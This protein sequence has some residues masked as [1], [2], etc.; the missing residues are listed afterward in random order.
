[1]ESAIRQY[2]LHRHRGD[3]GDLVSGMAVTM[4]L[5]VAHGHPKAA[6][7]VGFLNGGIA[8]GAALHNIRVA[9]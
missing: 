1:M 5:M 3:K 2:E 8:W 4:H 7:V 6:R 9:R